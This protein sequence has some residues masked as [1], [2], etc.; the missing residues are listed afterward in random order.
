MKNEKSVSNMA[1][2]SVGK[3][4]RVYSR[5]PLT[6]LISGSDRVLVGCTAPVPILP[7]I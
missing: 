7:A 3:D 2:E 5:F 1:K 4:V 6:I